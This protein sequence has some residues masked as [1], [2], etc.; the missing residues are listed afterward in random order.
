MCTF[1]ARMT[2]ET[3]MPNPYFSFKR[4][5]V[6]HD[7]CAMKVGTD[8]VLLGAWTHVDTSQRILDI[9][10]GSGLVALML[11]QRCEASI[12][13]IDI[14]SEA[15]EQ[16]QINIDA[17]DWKERLEVYHTALC[18]FSPEHLFDTIVSN[19]P[20]FVDSLKCS[21]IQR[22]TAR[23][24]DTLTSEQL[25]GNVSRMLCLEGEFSLVLPFEQPESAISIG[26][27]YGLYPTRHTR[28]ITRPGLPP[29]R[30][31]LA[32]KK[33][34]EEYIPQDLVIELERH[35]YSKEY[36]ALTKEFYLK[37]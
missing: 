12:T 19:P 6:Y 2:N 35:V 30:S 14:D 29:K 1:E 11:A 7:K 8:G 20:Y 31:L 21:D 22:N 27:K 5:T 3:D 32:F 10:T 37:M 18:K 13:A 23:H 36:I 4:F 28:V 24:N 25:F 9:G 26:E 16:A 15:V 17:S 34:P 33:H